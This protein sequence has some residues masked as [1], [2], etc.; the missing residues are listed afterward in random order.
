MHRDNQENK[1]ERDRLQE[2]VRD[3]EHKASSEQLKSYAD[4][5]EQ[6]RN[7]DKSEEDNVNITK[8]RD[9]LKDQVVELERRL[10]AASRLDERVHMNDPEPESEVDED[11]KQ[12]SQ[13]EAPKKLRY[14]NVCL[15]SVDKMSANVRLYLFML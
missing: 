9:S 12:P 13:P 2:Q 3:L 8:E 6:Q 1:D 7:L 4:A 14:C 10:K 11:P 15:K 5:I